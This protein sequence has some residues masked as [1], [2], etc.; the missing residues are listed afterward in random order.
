MKKLN[1]FIAV[2]VLSQCAV[3]AAYAINTPVMLLAASEAINLDQ[4]VAN[5]KKDTSKKVL[6]AETIQIEGK[7]VHVIKVLTDDG[8]IKK[9]QIN[10]SPSK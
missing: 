5:V 8:H 3:L 10:S 4:A 9:L 2:A 7:T 1:K 6:S